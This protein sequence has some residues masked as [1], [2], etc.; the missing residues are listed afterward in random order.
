ANQTP[1]FAESTYAFTLD[2][3]A[4][5]ETVLGALVATDADNDALT[6]TIT[7]GNEQGYFGL[8]A[9]GDA[10][11]VTKASAVTIPAGM[12]TLTVRVTDGEGSSET[13]V[14]VTV[15][16]TESPQPIAFASEN[17]TFELTANCQGTFVGFL[18]VRNSGNR[19]LVYTITGGSNVFTLDANGVLITATDEVATGT[20]T[21][22]VSVSEGSSVDEATVTIRVENPLGGRVAVQDVTLYPVPVTSVLHWTAEEHFNEVFVFDLNGQLLIKKQLS[23]GEQSLDVSSLKAGIYVLQLV[24]ESNSV[25]VRFTKE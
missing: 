13:T 20:Y 19:S 18:P 8:N 17:F 23:P 4:A 16:E 15:T 10:S 14:N 9:A 5:Q 12:Y 6:F 1:M 3:Q 24:N 2:G 7:A 25:S 11:L 22:Q 21:L